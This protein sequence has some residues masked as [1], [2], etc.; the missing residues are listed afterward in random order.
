M[1]Y[2]SI[3]LIFAVSVSSCSVT[4]NYTPQTSVQE[5]LYRDNNDND[6]TSLGTLS[7][8]QIFTDPE[9]KKL[10]NEGIANNPQILQAYTRIN[11]A[12]AY[13]EQSGAAFLPSLNANAGT[14]FA[15]LSDYQA[16]GIRSA[17]QFQLG[18]NSVWELDIWGKLKSSRKAQFA[19]LL[20][21]QAGMRAVQTSVV[22]SI[23]LFYYNLL[24][25]D[26][27]LKITQQTVYNWDTTVTTLKALKE[28]ARVTEAAVVQSE[29]QRY[30]AEV[31]IPDLKQKIAE[32]ENALSILIGRPPSEILRSSIYL[33]QEP[34]EI[35]TGTP[36][37][38]LSNRPDV[39]QAEYNLRY[40]FE[41]TNVAKTYFYPSLNISGSA[42]MNSLKIENLFNPAAFTASIGA[43]LAQ[44]VFNNKLNKT[45]LKVSEAQQQDALINFHNIL[46]TAGSEV[47]NAMLLYQTSKDKSEIRNKQ[48]DALQKAV[49]YTGELLENGFAT[50]TEIITARQSLLQ[51]ELGRINDRLQSLT[52]IVNLYKSL[53]GGWK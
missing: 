5:K 42:G 30:A 16:P 32:T 15:H 31:T 6:T 12:Q 21:S 40:Y 37:L 43:G 1:K 41:M 4:K 2:F 47:S 50:Y 19:N 3:I 36:V 20:Q 45:R 11:Q 25:L 24:A 51:A 39:Q 48:I 35:T 7:W 27:Q 17:T 26:E 46:L 13:Y 10:I 38:L 52:A 23:A 53:G 14:T 44:P 49:D 8:T 33:Q 29:A 18:V 28:A 34:T 9:L 22:S